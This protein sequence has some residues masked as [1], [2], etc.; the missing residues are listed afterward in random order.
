M[1]SKRSRRDLDSG[2][3]NGLAK[4]AGSQLRLQ[5][6]TRYEIDWMSH[7]RRQALLQTDKPDKTNRP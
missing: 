3:T 5:C 4:D 6:G 7:C 1:S 2:G